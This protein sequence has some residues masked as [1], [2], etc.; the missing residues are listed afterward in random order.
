MPDQRDRS[1]LDTGA[2]R[3]FDPG[4][5]LGRSFPLSTGVRVRLRFARPT[6]QDGIAALLADQGREIS[7]QRIGELVR[8]DPRRRIVICGTALLGQAETVVAVGTIELGADPAEPKVIVD[9]SVGDGLAELV[10]GAL[11]GRARATKARRVA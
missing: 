1:G 7:A 6:D 3:G 11:V 4:P 9:S 2:Q 8:F 5:L 10:S